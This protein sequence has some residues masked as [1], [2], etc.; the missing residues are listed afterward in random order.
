VCEREGECVCER[1]SVG[2]KAPRA[3]GTGG[4]GAPAGIYLLIYLIYIFRSLRCVCVK[5]TER[6]CV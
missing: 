2:S 3:G 1:A 6:V 4:D 5:E